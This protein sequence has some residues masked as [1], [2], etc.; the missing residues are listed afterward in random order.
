MRADALKGGFADAPVD[1]AHGFR[2]AMNAMARPGYIET[3]RGAVPPAP[4][5]V[6]AG[7]L[8]LTLCDPET[9]LYLAGAHDCQDMRDWVAFHIGAPV[10]ARQEAL[11]V[12]G[13][14]DAVLP[15]EGYALGTSEYPD[16]SATLIVEMD[17]LGGGGAILRGPGIKDTA[18]LSLPD[19]ISLFQ[20]NA[21]LFP[22]GLDFFFTAGDQV[23][24]LPRTTKVTH[25]EVV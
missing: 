17:A 21:T 22:L 7:S 9:P 19:D 14:W 5:S 16:Q 23:A 18:T 20:R 1:A 24:A 3:L 13:A 8:L 6:A 10:V 11:F 25:E 4:V 15:L 2:A 12:L